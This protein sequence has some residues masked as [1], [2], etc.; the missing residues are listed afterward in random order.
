MAEYLC[1]RVGMRLEEFSAY[2]FTMRYPPIA[3]RAV[4]RYPLAEP[5]E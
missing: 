5:P 3:A 2:R 1:A 4:M